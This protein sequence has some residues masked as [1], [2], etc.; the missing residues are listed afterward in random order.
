MTKVRVIAIELYAGA[1]TRRARRA[2]TSPEGRGEDPGP[3]RF[4]QGDT[5][6]RKE[7]DRARVSRR[8]L[9]CRS[10][11]LSRE[12]N[13]RGKKEHA[14]KKG[15]VVASLGSHEKSSNRCVST[16]SLLFVFN[17]QEARNPGWVS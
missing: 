4:A 12:N 7:I 14:A 17:L 8:T 6:I 15:G 5:R 16:A 3:I 2:T 13:G 1:L 10:G 11:I 9:T